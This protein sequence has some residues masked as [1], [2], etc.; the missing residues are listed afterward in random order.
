MRKRDVARI[1]LDLTL[2][3][4]VGGIILVI[5]Y[6]IT[7]PIIY[8]HGVI[9]KQNSLKALIPEADRIL[10]MGDWEIHGKHAEYFA[11]DRSGDHI[12]YIIQSYGK[13]Y[14]SFINTLIA[15]DK[16]F[17]VKKIKVLEHGE[18]PG[19]GDEIMT[20]QF[21]GQFKD[22]TF[23]HLKVQKTDTTSDIQAISGATISSRA[24]TEDAV[25]NGLGFLINTFSK[26]EEKHVGNYQAQ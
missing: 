23:D 20:E 9:E 21:M 8:K 6:G 5:V 24:V 2:I 12:G 26:K 14:S 25:K 22:K 18:T 10:K 16:D 7:S 3:Y 4:I 11:A 13:G 19:L 15:V 17:K 1:T